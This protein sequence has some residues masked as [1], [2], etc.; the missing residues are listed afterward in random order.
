[1]WATMRR[2]IGGGRE[3]SVGDAL[4][5]R[6]L[7]GVVDSDMA[8]EELAEVLR[9]GAVLRNDHGAE[10]FEPFAHRRGFERL[11]HCIV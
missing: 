6:G 8:L 1:M 5:L 11:H 10:P 2:A 9:R 7:T 4:E 3:L